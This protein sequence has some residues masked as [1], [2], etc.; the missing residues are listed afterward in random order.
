MMIKKKKFKTADDDAAAADDE[1]VDKKNIQVT[2]RS[3]NYSW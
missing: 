1:F 3:K 2:R